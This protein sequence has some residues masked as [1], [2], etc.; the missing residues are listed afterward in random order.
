MTFVSIFSVRAIHAI[1]IGLLRISKYVDDI[2]HCLRS[3]HN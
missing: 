3:Y 1:S 2:S